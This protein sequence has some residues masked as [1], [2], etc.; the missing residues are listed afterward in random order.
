MRTT[1]TLEPDVQELLKH[2]MR[3]QDAP[4]KRVV[5]D[6]LR[7]GLRNPSPSSAVPFV[8]PVFDMGEPLIEVTNFNRLNDELEVE[9]FVEK[10]RRE[11][12]SR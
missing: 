2:A 3:E 7:K 11:S 10:M 6:A 8:Q 9:A 4:F 1:I 12:Q 5:N